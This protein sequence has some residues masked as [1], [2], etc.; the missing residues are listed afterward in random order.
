[1]Y[2]CQSKIPKSR[3]EMAQPRG[4]RIASTYLAEKRF[5]RS[6]YTIEFWPTSVQILV[7]SLNFSPCKARADHY[8]DLVSSLLR[9]L[10]HLSR[11]RSSVF[12]FFLQKRIQSSLCR[13]DLQAQSRKIKIF[14][15][16]L[17]PCNLSSN[18]QRR[19]MQIF[20]SKFVSYKH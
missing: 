17:H 12:T 2:S 8:I 19:R 5:L 7:R 14:I 16:V 3:S 18:Y 9:S 1:M 15:W 11:C 13:S 20:N 4:L 6:D 10:K